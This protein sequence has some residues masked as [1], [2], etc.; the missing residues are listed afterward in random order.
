MRRRGKT[1]V[2]CKTDDRSFVGSSSLP[3]VVP[4]ESSVPSIPIVCSLSGIDV[5]LKG[6]LE[7]LL[8]FGMLA[9][10][11]DKGSMSVHLSVLHLPHVVITRRK[12]EDAASTGFP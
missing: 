8:L 11:D 12:L 4:S 6:P 9:A 5:A 2:L 10:I 1:R 7:H 3:P